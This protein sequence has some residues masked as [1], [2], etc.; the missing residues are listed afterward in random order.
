[1]S[2]EEIYKKMTEIKNMRVSEIKSM[3]KGNEVIDIKPLGM[4]K[5]NNEIT[6][7]PETYMLIEQY[8]NKDGKTIEVER[9]YDADGKI[10][11]GNNR[12]DEYPEI[13]LVSPND[14][15]KKRLEELVKEMD[16][17]GMKTLT[18]LEQ[19]YQDMAAQIGIK[20]D[21][22]G[23]ITIIEMQAL[24]DAR[25]RLN[26]YMQSIEE[27]SE[28]P[29]REE[30]KY[31]E[32][33]DNT[34]DFINFDKNEQ[35]TE[36]DFTTSAQINANAY[37]NEYDTIA[38]ALKISD[39][40]YQKIAIVPSNQIKENSA[41][42][43]YSFVGVKPDGTAELLNSNN[44]NGIIQPEMDDIGRTNHEIDEK[45]RITEGEGARENFKIAGTRL[46]FELE[47]EA[48]NLEVKLTTYGK[49]INGNESL[50]VPV[51]T[52]SLE[53]NERAVNRL[54][55]EHPAKTDT[56]L[57]EVDRHNDN[58][59]LRAPEDID[60]D[61]KTVSHDWDK[62]IA[63]L[64][65]DADVEEQFTDGELLSM[66]ENGWAKGDSEEAIAYNIKTDAYELG[67]M[68]ENTRRNNN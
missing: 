24:E 42:T 50:S 67:R 19:E 54:T 25:I 63:E 1:M 37:I 13:I 20:K 53:P 5:K 32:Q 9:Y 57:D 31:D 65:E 38:S 62:L 49:G 33:Q 64:K 29:N 46:G 41:T 11:G 27:G 40:G 28:E 18:E 15:L 39:E 8:T 12:D 7:M 55:A 61:P 56:G 3:G 35:L 47:G 16:L 2:E 43:R 4:D 21:D 60:G 6:K 17:K 58:E 51:Q 34:N 26:E 59:N 23:T 36:N 14:E 30:K 68:Q 45:G 44:S 22:I 52:Y 66:I 48:S 10:L